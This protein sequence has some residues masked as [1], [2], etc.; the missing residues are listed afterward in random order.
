MQVP[1]SN[2]VD[3]A[4]FHSEATRLLAQQVPPDTVEWSAAPAQAV[5]EESLDAERAAIRNRAARAIIPQS[6]VRMSELVVLHR[7][8]GR[9]DLL[10]RSLWRLVYE[11]ELKNDYGDHDLARLRQMAQ[12]VRRDIQKMKTK[13][14][15]RPLHLRGEPEPV[16]WYEPTHYISESVGAW[17]AK[18]Q[19][20]AHWILLTPDRSM[21]WDGIHLLSAPAVAPGQEPMAERSDGDWA[22]VLEA[23]P[24]R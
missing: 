16:A 18:R 11:P 9:F 15:F 20:G 19:P 4:G 3:V 1:L 5:E 14:V 13:L 7:D 17:L 12:A 2:Q 22:R 23:M 24:W 10:Y 8:P 21:R 6:F